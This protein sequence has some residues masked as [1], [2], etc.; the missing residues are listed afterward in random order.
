MRGVSLLITGNHRHWVHWSR[1]IY[2][3]VIIY[4]FEL[5]PAV[6]L[7]TDFDRCL[8][9]IKSIKHEK[10]FLIVSASFVGQILS[11]VNNYKFILAIFI[12]C[13]NPQQY[14]SLVD[15]HNEIIGI[16]TDQN[17]L[18]EAIRNKIKLIEKQTLAFNLYD[19]K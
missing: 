15:V 3:P 8:D 5:N 11:Q 14:E 10:I 16:Y 1:S 6:R 2:S 4:I 18:F 12:F 13:D 9:L 19:Q 7:Y 17:N